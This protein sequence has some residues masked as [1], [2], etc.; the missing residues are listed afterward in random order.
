[1]PR[2]TRRRWARTCASSVWSAATARAIA[3]WPR[4]PCGSDRGGITRAKGFVTPVKTRILA[5]G[6]HSAKQQVVRIDRAGGRASPA[7]LRRVEAAL[8]AALRHA[9]AVI[10]SDYGGGVATPALWRRALAAAATEAAAHRARGLALRLVRV[11]GHD[12]LHAERVRGGGAPGRAHRRRPRRA[13]AVRP[14]AASAAGMRRRAHHAR[15]PRHGALRTRLARPITF[16][17]SDPIRL[18]TS[19]APATP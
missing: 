15:Q 10:V 1:M 16:P 11:L 4:C 18:R 2:R 13:R 12:R 5:G 14:H 19:P 7:V 6:V 8:A 17:S 3:C 9:D